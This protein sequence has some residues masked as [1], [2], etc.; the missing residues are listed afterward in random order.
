[1]LLDYALPRFNG[2]AAL[3]L[4]RKIRPE[5]PAII[6]SGVIE[7]DLAAETLKIGA[8][9]Y[10]AK[11][12]LERL[13]PVTQRLLRVNARRQ[14]AMRRFRSTLAELR[15]CAAELAEGEG[16]H[17]AAKRLGRLEQVAADLESLAT[18]LVASS[19]P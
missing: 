8:A 3:D 15:A 1:V 10:V 5:A 2:V 19:R 14:D 6:L 18:E 7:H 4:A 17:V 11:D 16:P 12:N 13:V 9:D